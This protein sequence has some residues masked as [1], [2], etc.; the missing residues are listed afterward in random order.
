MH[1]FFKFASIH[2]HF[3]SLLLQLLVLALEL[4]EHLLHLYIFAMK[5]IQ[6]PLVALDLLNIGSYLVFS[7]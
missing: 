1:E 3:I 7:L 5:V 6:L 4:L 2:P